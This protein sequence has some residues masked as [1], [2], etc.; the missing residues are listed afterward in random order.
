MLGTGGAESHLWHAN[1]DSSKNTRV[2]EIEAA[3]FISRT[4]VFIKNIHAIYHN[5]HCCR[6]T[7]TKATCTPKRH[8]ATCRSGVCYSTIMA[9][10][11]E[12]CCDVS[13]WCALLDD[14]GGCGESLVCFCRERSISANAEC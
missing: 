3:I 6:V 4:R 8:F 9:G 10:C 12:S 14:N 2:L 11:G 5:R 7:H 1:C 13:L